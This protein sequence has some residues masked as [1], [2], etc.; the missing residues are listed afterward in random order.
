[1]HF[2]FSTGEVE[3]TI[4]YR[5][6]Q[7][8]N[9][10]YVLSLFWVQ[11]Y[12]KR[13][14]E[15]TSLNKSQSRE[16]LILIISLKLSFVAASFFQSIFHSS[17]RLYSSIMWHSHP[18]LRCHPVNFKGK[19]SPFNLQSVMAHCPAK[20]ISIILLIPSIHNLG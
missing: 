14:G 10:S 4:D 19:P 11:W 16:T 12:M 6:C 18:R 1:M 7:Y 5:P 13:R 17:C 3:R 2:I 20:S 8:C 9:P 15:K